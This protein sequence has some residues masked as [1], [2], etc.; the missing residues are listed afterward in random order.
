MLR[1]LRFS[2]AVLWV[3]LSFAYSVVAAEPPRVIATFPQNGSQDVDP[4]TTQISV[5]FNQAMTDKSWSWAYEDKSKF[6]VTTAK[7]YYTDG[8]TKCV[9]PVKLEPNKEYAIWINTAKFKN[10]KSAS[11]APAQPYRLAFRTK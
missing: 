4:S 1:R 7:P 9:L 10:F 2:S 3:L 6:P 8:G 11:G 5:T